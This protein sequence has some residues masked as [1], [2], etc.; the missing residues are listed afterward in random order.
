MDS[1]QKMMLKNATAIVMMD[2]FLKRNKDSIVASVGP[3]KRNPDFWGFELTSDSG[4]RISVA[5]PP[6]SKTL[7]IF[8]KDEI[9][10]PEENELP[11]ILLQMKNGA[12]QPSG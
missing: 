11:A 7:E 10:Y 8:F 6:D 1:M 12:Y 2:E 4:E 3:I 9:Y 5:I